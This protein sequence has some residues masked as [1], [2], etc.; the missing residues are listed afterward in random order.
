MDTARGCFVLTTTSFVRRYPCMLR[1][2]KFHAI[3]FIFHLC[4]GHVSSIQVGV[5]VRVDI[6]AASQHVRT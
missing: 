3:A 5:D 1:E 6:T 2:N 4:L